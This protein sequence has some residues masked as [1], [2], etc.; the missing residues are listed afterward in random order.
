MII[1]NYFEIADS[2]IEKLTPRDKAEYFLL[3]AVF[4]TVG[5][6]GIQYDIMTYE[7]TTRIL[8]VR[9]TGLLKW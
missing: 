1:N 4:S 7:G 8:A 2:C 9:S 3:G 5:S 6:E